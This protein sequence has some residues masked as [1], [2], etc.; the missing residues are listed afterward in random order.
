M[1]RSPVPTGSSF[2]YGNP[3][4]DIIPICDGIKPFQV[5][6]GYRIISTT[7]TV[8]WWCCHNTKRCKCNRKWIKAVIVRRSPL[9]NELLSNCNVAEW[10]RTIIV[11]IIYVDAMETNAC[12]VHW[13]DLW[14]SPVIGIT[15]S[16]RIAFYSKCNWKGYY[17]RDSVWRG[18]PLAIQRPIAMNP[19]LFCWSTVYHSSHV[20][21]ALLRLRCETKRLDALT[22]PVG[23][24][25]NGA[26]IQQSETNDMGKLTVRTVPEPPRL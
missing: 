4:S 15:Y 10:I 6:R 1:H 23:L 24:C 12:G 13:F 14:I 25:C 8:F 26:T 2:S 18:S 5:G 20:N 21:T 9:D 7:E 3:A 17:R 22:F 19:I 16:C 11:R